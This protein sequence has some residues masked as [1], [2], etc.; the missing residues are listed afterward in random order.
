MLAPELDVVGLVCSQQRPASDRLPPSRLSPRQTVWWQ[1]VADNSQPLEVNDSAR[2]W[3]EKI[4]DAS[5]GEGARPNSVTQTAWVKEPPP[6]PIRRM[7]S[8]E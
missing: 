2:L 7:V 8:S 1:T 4:T 3:A 6:A 5:K